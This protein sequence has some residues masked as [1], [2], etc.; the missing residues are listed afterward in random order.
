MLLV[1]K[2]YGFLPSSYYAETW[3]VRALDMK[4]IGA[5]EK[6]CW[7]RMLRVP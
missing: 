7:R 1:G 4:N 2:R 3:A 5:F 6:W